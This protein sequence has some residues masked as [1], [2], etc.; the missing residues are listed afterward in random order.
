MMST[1]IASSPPARGAGSQRLRFLS[2]EPPNA[3]TVFADQTGVI[4]PNSAF[5]IRS[6]F[7]HPVIKEPEWSLVVEGKVQRPITLR[8][9]D[10]RALPARTLLVTLECAGNGRA[11]LQPPVEGELWQYGAVSTAEW[12][13]VSLCAVLEEAGLLPTAQEVVIEGADQ[14]YVAAANK[15]LAFARSLPLQRALHP[16][17]LL[18]YAMN[19]EALPVEHGFPL[20]LVVPGWY[21]MASVKWVRRVEAVAQPFRGYFQADSYV[22]DRAEQTGAKPVP[23]TTAGPRSLIIAPEEGARLP[24]GSHILR[25]LAWAGAAPVCQAEVSLDGGATWEQACFTSEPTCYAWRRWEFVWHAAAPGAVTLLSRA[26]DEDGN[27]QPAQGEWNRL[28]YA[29]NAIQ[30]VRVEV[31]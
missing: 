24:R 22:L 27:T 31:I 26:L 18:A 6:H 4:T 15:T 21:G 25:G 13:G 30:Q 11:Y 9:A 7:A 23:L 16:D 8:Y 29:N 1:E 14:G 10:L 17:T 28:G 3:E 12:T 20:R 19:G 2:D 5:Y